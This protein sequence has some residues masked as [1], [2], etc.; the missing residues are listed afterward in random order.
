MKL[1]K[2]EILRIVDEFDL[3]NIR[4]YKLIK[5]GLVNHNYALETNRGKYIVRI[6]RNPDSNKINHL[7][8]QF[9]I[10]DYLR[11]KRFPY[12]LPFP[13]KTKDSEEILSVGNNKIWIYKMIEGKNYDR[14]DI[15]QIR[16]MAK[17]LATYH[18]SISGFNGERQKDESEERI[19]TG[20]KKMQNI[21]VKD[22]V[23]RLASKYRDYFKEVFNNVSKI[24]FS[25]NLLFVHSDFDSSNVLF[26]KGKLI[27]IIDFDDTFYSSRVFDI[28]ISIRDSCYNRVN[29][30]DINKLNIF[31]GE[32]ERIS[33]LSQEEKKMI[34]PIIL[35]ANVD[36]FVWIYTRMKKEK[37]K[38]VKY[39]QE[40][41][42]S[43]KNIIKDREKILEVLLR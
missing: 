42:N 25:K 38:R 36:F 24:K 6:I 26:S 40:M 10:F 28:A 15:S 16:L 5:G 4:N 31:L 17:A 19:I 39:M 11:K 41:I 32:Y 12:L 35:K 14:P 29:G 1:T 34:I 3:G 2:K 13:L 20:F 18:N 9:R 22:S 33:K 8:I 27:G 23:D 7:R 21:S 37:G 30:I 43:T